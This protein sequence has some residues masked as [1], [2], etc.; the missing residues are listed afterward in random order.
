MQGKVG[1]VIRGQIMQGSSKNAK[2]FGL[3]RSLEFIFPATRG[4]LDGC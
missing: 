3:A 1:G 2:E 4:S